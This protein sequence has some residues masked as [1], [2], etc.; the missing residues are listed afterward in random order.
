MFAFQ[1]SDPNSP[2]F[3]VPVEVNVPDE[4]P[5]VTLY[6]VEFSDDPAFNVKITRTDTS[7]VM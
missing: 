4:R 7:T 5:D 2:R 1:F 6:S 3:E